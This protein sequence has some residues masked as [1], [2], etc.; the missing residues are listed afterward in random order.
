MDFTAG[1]GGGLPQ[2]SD[3]SRL[4]ALREYGILDTAR[5]AAF[6]EITQL[7]AEICDAPIAMVS[8]VEDTRQ[9]FKSEVGFGACE[10][11]IEESI[12][13]H[14]ILNGDIFVVA[15]A[16]RDS[17]F[18][19]H[20][21][22]AG[23]RHIRFYAGAVLKDC[24][25]F[26]LGTV[27]VLDTQARPAGLSPLQARSLAALSRSVIRELDL[28]QAN[29]LLREGEERLRL[30]L[31]AGR[32]FAWER[33]LQT[34][35]VTRSDSAYE[36]IGLG[37][38]P[39]QEFDA[40]VYPN[41]KWRAPMWGSIIDQEEIRYVRPDGRVIW[42]A[43]RSTVV[44]ESETDKRLIGV[45][46]DITDRKLVEE[47]LWR[48]AN[49][50]ALTGL[51]NRALF[52][53][54]LTEALQHAE[55]NGYAV[56]LLLLDLDDFKAVN[57]TRGH[58]AGDVLLVE[59]GRRLSHAVRDC[60]TVA[61]IGGDEFAIICVETEAEDALRLADSLASLLARPIPYE[62]RSLSIRASMG[63]AAYPR[64]HRVPNELMKDADI[65]LYHAK[66]KQRGGAVIYTALARDRLEQ[67][68][69]VLE[70]VREGLNCDQFLPFYQPKLS[71]RTGQVLGF[72]ALVRWQHPDRGLLAPG[73]FGPAFTDPETAIAIGNVMVRRVLDDIRSWRAQGLDCGRVAVNFSA[74]EF[75][76]E[77]LAKRVLGMLADA[78]VPPRCFEV[79][80][81]ETVLL[82]QNS[83][84]TYEVLNTL[85][86]AGVSVALDDFGTGYASLTHLK[87]YPVH[88]IK[89]DQSFVRDL[90]TD[91]EDVA[92]VSAVIRL[93]QSLGMEVT[94]EG[95][96]TQRQ[97]DI[98][99]EMG[100]DQ[101]QGYFYAKPMRGAQA[102]AMMAKSD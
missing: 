44:A 45:T 17:R 63:I 87:C 85:S 21:L 65:A 1:D 54:R 67:R 49:Q 30:A 100:C 78:G 53:N 9:W 61:R 74:A 64:H 96:E 39:A 35:F 57:D 93:G 92:I 52:Q 38:G 48:M 70:E 3:Q 50:D 90:E 88:H 55:A 81:T 10:T 42:L 16:T 101:A 97:A 43:A 86:E 33:N 34:D 98:L 68:V 13:A 56:S 59:V 72:E 77:D 37:S 94:A 22:V 79:E 14:A 29:R 26:A 27:C 91:K 51:G 47:K 24:N 41:D 7:A 12:C 31:Q 83:E 32:M 18:A 6:D 80:I 20:P 36:L 8:F 89:I 28:R 75:A 84:N 76:D 82:E 25:G 95:V 60:D 102:M 46:F 23:E 66:T 99:A 2:W 69:R 5:E 58:D 40:N 15:D 11:S 71:L 4:C 73:S 19:K 62:G